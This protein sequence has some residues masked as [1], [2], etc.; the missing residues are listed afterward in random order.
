MRGRNRIGES[1][2]ASSEAEEEN[3]DLGTLRRRA[4]ETAQRRDH[5][6]DIGG[7]AVALNCGPMEEHDQWEG[8]NE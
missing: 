5:E 6:I 3:M 7:P 8:W 2:L 1:R 4:E